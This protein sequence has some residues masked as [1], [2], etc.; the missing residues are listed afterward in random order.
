MAHMDIIG[1]RVTPE[2]KARFRALANHE[3]LSES[4]LL[5][6]MID[7]ALLNVAGQVVVTVTE[8]ERRPR[9]CRISVR[10]APNDLTL[11]N[12]R[13]IARSMPTATY[14]SVLLRAHLRD[15]APLPNAELL[16]LKASVAALGAI[17]RN[18]NQLARAA[19]QGQSVNPSRDDLHALL[20][21]CMAL[22]DHVKALIKANTASWR[23][24]HAEPS[25]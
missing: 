3:Q 20:K 2:M 25:A 1:T 16:A 10:L 24:G 17:G 22:R 4:A 15:L 5:I 13:A 9:G 18:L 12:A 6:R 8:L 7:R 23:K 19:N 11:L 14:A 21:A